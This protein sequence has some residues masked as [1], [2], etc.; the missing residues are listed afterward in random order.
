MNTPR[1][2]VIIP[3]YNHVKYVAEAIQ[4]VIDQTYQDFEIVITDDG[5]TDGTVAEIEKFNDP[6]IRLFTL[7][8]NSGAGV[9]S[10]N[11]VK[12]SRGEYLAMLSSDD[13]FLPEK[14]EKQVR[15]LDEHPDI[16]AVFGYA[17]IIDDE[18]NNIEDESNYY[19][20]VFRQPNRTRFEWL[21]HFFYKG[22]CL[23][24][25]SVLAR[26]EVYTE[27]GPPDP[28]YAQL[29]DYYR[30]IRTCLK[31]EIYILPENLIKFRAHAGGVNASGN[32]LVVRTRGSFEFTRILRHYLEIDSVNELLKIFPDAA[33][34]GEPEKD[35]IPYFIAR[36]AIDNGISPPLAQ[37]FGIN[38]IYEILGDE[39]MATILEKRCGFTYSKF[40]ELTGGHDY[41]NIEA[42][43]KLTSKEGELA[44]VQ[45]DLEAILNS[46]S[47]K[48]IN[49][50]KR[51]KSL[52]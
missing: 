17:Q 39:K 36:L 27:L 28:R 4:S 43:D 2:S 38:V 16:W 12:E 26:R 1:V 10:K 35:I 15:F 34:Y 33:K 50:L 45:N 37:V 9:A 47:W 41:F 30:W 49:H 46:R 52:I 19:T 20:T 48:I 21:N 51:V 7:D 6:R 42:K 22:N 24:H 18:G 29:G 14:L 11:C 32:R 5:S 13:I 3:S 25:P 40:I 8:K 31:H 44:A 23:C